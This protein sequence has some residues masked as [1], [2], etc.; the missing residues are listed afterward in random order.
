MVEWRRQSPETEELLPAGS[1]RRAW[2]EAADDLPPAFEF[3]GIAALDGS[4][5]LEWE[6]VDRER[7]VMVRI[8]RDPGGHT[9]A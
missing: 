1:H 4:P 3:D 7:T 9:P 5:D 8:V 6:F 2:F